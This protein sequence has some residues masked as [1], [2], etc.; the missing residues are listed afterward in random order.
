MTDFAKVDELFEAMNGTEQ[1]SAQSGVVAVSK[2]ALTDFVREHKP[3][4]GRYKSMA[5]FQTA[6]ENAGRCHASSFLMPAYCARG[7]NQ[8]APCAL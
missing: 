3:R 4:H 6:I 7:T 5:L 1:D 8:Q 2:I